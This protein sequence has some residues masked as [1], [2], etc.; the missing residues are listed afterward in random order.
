M[1]DNNSN[2]F[3]ETNQNGEPFSN[4]EPLKNEDFLQNEESKQYEESMQDDKSIQNTDAIQNMDTTQNVDAAQNVD[5]NQNTDANQYPNDSKADSTDDF[6]NVMDFTKTGTNESF[7][8]SFETSASGP[9]GKKPSGKLIAGIVLLAVVIIGAI[10]A[11]A[12]R[13]SL[14]NTYALMTKSP[15]EYYSYT[16]SKSINKGI[17]SYTSYYSKSLKTYNDLK[18]TGVAEDANVKLTVS[19]QFTSLI[20]LPDFQSLEANIHSQS[21]GMNKGKYDIGLSYNG[22]S[23]A[24]LNTLINNET[25]QMYFKVPEL[26]SAYLLLNMDEMMSTYDPEM[27]GGSYNSYMQKVEAL[28][29]SDALSPAI[30]N[31]ILKKYSNLIIE[32]IDDVKMEKNTKVT[33]SDISS[34]Y[35]KLAV[36][37]TGEDAYNMGL[38][39]LNE[40]KTDDNLKSLY[41]AMELGTEDE[42]A[43]SLDSA[44]QEYTAEKDTMTTSK[45]SILMNVYVDNTG[46]IMGREFVSNDADVSNGLGYYIT[47]T[48]NK[49]GFKAYVS[50]GDVD[51]IDFSGNGTYS[52]SGFNGKSTL[53]YS[54]YSDS[55]GDYTTYKFDIAMENAKID[56]EKGYVNGKFTLTSDLLMG[57]EVSLQCTGDDKQQEYLFSVLYGNME[58]A[59]VDIVGKKG[60]YE[61]FEYPTDSDEVYDAM[62]DIDSYSA[63]MDIEGF[64]SK[65]QSVT[66]IDLNSLIS[67][68]LYGGMY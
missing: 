1:G 22:Q 27:Y 26:S 25:S 8:Q 67:N 46:R 4:E 53:S 64:T 47:H 28:I 23:L 13:N 51:I 36:T 6:S 18:E 20:G 3:D 43:S 56:S 57:A 37:L 11:Y 17:D 24:T 34:S 30:I 16:E 38:A 19:P 42:Y 15:L 48:G 9:K 12:N 60:T 58:A 59:T 61:E 21:K 41:V 35:T 66:G 68:L 40:A 55:Y 39:I 31:T 44:L 5:A 65:L 10:T 50:E 2:N 63:T 52:G 33:A 49:I 14:S 45:E 32:N 54:E 62:T 29:N 7:E